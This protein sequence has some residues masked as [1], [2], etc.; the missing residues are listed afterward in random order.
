MQFILEI[1]RRQSAEDKPYTLAAVYEGEGSDTVALALTKLNA[2]SSRR[3]IHGEPF[4]PIRWECSCLQKKCGA[5][6]MVINGRPM[7]ACDARLGEIAK[8][9]KITAA[10]L[11]KFPLVADLVVDRGPMF[12]ALAEA[13]LWL[14]S[15]GSIPAG[16]TD[17]AFEASRCLQCGCCLEVCPNFYAGGDFFGMSAAVPM[18][19]L[20]AAADNAERRELSEQYKKHVYSGCGK[21]LACRSICPAGIDA[22]RLLVNSNAAAVWKRRFGSRKK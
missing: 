18:T 6:A 3:D 8:R 20:F 10:P 2:D 1:E 4:E 9:G 11:K 16:N 5:C 13:R 15:T 19:R 17:I 12:A 7:L 22:D 14:E 21:S